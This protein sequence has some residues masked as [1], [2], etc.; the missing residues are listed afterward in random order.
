ME[1]ARGEKGWQMTN[2]T[3]F[4]LAFYISCRVYGDVNWLYNGSLGMGYVAMPLH[5][6]D[7]RKLWS[8]LMERRY[9]G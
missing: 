4:A 6:F 5:N 7:I 8:S 2:D 9:G 1:H 3:D